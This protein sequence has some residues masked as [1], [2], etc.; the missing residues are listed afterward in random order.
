MIIEVKDGVFYDT[1]LEVQ[2][3]DFGTWMTDEVYPKMDSKEPEYDSF[4]RAFRCSVDMGTCMVTR[5]REYL[6]ESTSCALKNEI[7]IVTLKN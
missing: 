4:M 5:E 6:Y 7:I 1:E 3:M 2:S